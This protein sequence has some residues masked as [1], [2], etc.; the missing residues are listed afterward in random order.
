MLA[1]RSKQS[2]LRLSQG[3][4]TLDGGR[5]ELLH[6]NTGLTSPAKVPVPTNRGPGTPGTLALDTRAEPG[7]WRF[8]TEVLV[9]AAGGLLP[10]F[11]ARCSFAPSM[12]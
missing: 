8:V 12:G 5:G 3:V 1:S 2:V 11:C 10:P 7:Y 4:G 9:V 6:V